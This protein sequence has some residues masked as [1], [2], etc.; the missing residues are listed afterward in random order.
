MGEDQ[1]DAGRNVDHARNEFRK[2]SKKVAGTN[3][4]IFK[5]CSTD[6]HMMIASLSYWATYNYQQMATQP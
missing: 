1:S 4:W 6:V 2:D 5:L 3:S